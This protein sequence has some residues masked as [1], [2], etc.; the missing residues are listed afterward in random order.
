MENSNKDNNAVLNFKEV[1][2]YLENADG[3]EPLVVA[4][5]LTDIEGISS[6]V[7]E[8]GKEGNKDWSIEDIKDEWDAS[9]CLDDIWEEYFYNQDRPFSME[10]FALMCECVKRIYWAFYK[11]DEDKTCKELRGHYISLLGAHETLVAMSLFPEYIDEEHEVFSMFARKT[12]SA[13]RYINYKL[14]EPNQIYHIFERIV[15]YDFEKD[16]PETIYQ[17]LLENLA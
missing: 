10:L 4:L 15:W 16:T 5:D 12:I 17:R 7:K 8:D 3:S 2:E 13:I 6:D 1:V 9:W 11:I 14:S